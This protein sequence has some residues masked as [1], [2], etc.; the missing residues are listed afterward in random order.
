MS[1]VTY[2]REN[3]APNDHAP[4]RRGCWLM[5][6]V[7]AVLSI[8]GGGTGAVLLSLANE[9]NEIR[10]TLASDRIT[11]AVGEPFTVELAIEN[12]SLDTVTITSIGLDDRLTDGVRLDVMEP[13]YRNTRH[14]D[15][16][17]LGAWTG[18]NFDRQLFGGDT[19][20]VTMTLT[21]LQPGTYSG[22]VTVW[23]E[24]HV[25]GIPIERARHASL[26]IT[27]R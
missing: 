13:P 27:L 5:L 9:P 24:G 18:Y 10:T 20:A 16:P 6:L 14:R 26:D 12:V 1:Q 23:V 2:A 8:C 11:A 25:L 15:Y 17:L 4:R 21:G 3:A 22:D 7:L 19:L